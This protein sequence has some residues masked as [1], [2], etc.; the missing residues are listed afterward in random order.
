M[1]IL[2]KQLFCI[3][4]ILG[5]TAQ[6]DSLYAEDDAVISLYRSGGF[7]RADPSD[8]NDYSFTVN[9]DGQWKINLSR[10][11]RGFYGTLS[12]DQT[13]KLDDLVEAIKTADKSALSDPRIAD[14]PNMSVSVGKKEADRIK[15]KVNS[16]PAAA[17]HQWLEE[18]RKVSNVNVIGHLQF[19]SKDRDG[20]TKDWAMLT[21]KE[22]V[23]DRL[24]KE[25][26]ESLSGVD[27]KKQKLVLLKWAGSGQD[28]LETKLVQ[29]GK[30]TT[31][32]I[33]RFPGRTRDLRT[34]THVFV[35]PKTQEFEFKKK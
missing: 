27:F 20:L 28:R 18:I 1:R 3:L 5:F 15:L 24:G 21:G 32:E 25:A 17:M 4:V 7:R 14:L 19:A 11:G 9:G 16:K 31:L 34:H 12:M 33:Q 22:D 13:S 30:K 2:V 26:A 29:N 35:L 23:G 10:S 8:E 6:G